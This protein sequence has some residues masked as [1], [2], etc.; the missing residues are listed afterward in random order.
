[1]GPFCALQGA[2]EHGREVTAFHYVPAFRIGMLVEGIQ[3][4]P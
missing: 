2:F 4:T 1:M 3:V